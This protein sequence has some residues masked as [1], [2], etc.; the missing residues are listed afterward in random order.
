VGDADVNKPIVRAKTAHKRM[1]IINLIQAKVFGIIRWCIGRGGWGIPFGGDG[2]GAYP[3]DDHEY[4]KYHP[5]T[6]EYHLIPNA[7]RPMRQDK[8]SHFEPFELWLFSQF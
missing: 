8:K 6:D 5:N 1:R 3:T 7:E 4:Q 2:A